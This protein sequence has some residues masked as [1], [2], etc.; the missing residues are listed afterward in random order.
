MQSKALPGLYITFPLG[1]FTCAPDYLRV[2]P[3]RSTKLFDRIVSRINF[4]VDAS[5]DHAEEPRTPGMLQHPGRKLH[6]GSVELFVKMN[7]VLCCWHLE[8]DVEIFGPFDGAVATM[9]NYDVEV[10]SFD[11]PGGAE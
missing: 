4:N 9:L 5:G 1:A 6:T 10:V 2:A 11:N 3:E 7:D 8:P